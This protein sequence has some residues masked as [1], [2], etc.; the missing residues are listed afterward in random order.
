TRQRAER[1]MGR[2]DRRTRVTRAEESRGVT[3]GNRFGG[4]FDRGT[5]LA[6][7][8]SS[9]RFFHSDNV[10]C[11]QQFQAR[12]V[13]IGMALDLR[14]ERCQAAD[15]YDAEVEV[16][17]RS[18]RPVNEVGGAGVAA[19]R[20]NGDPDHRSKVRTKCLLFIDWTRL[21]AAI[22][23]AIRAHTMRR[24]GLGAM[25]AFAQGDGFECVVRPALRRPR[26][27]MSSFGIWHMYITSVPSNFRR[28]RNVQEFFFNAF[29][30]ASRGSSHAGWH[31]HVPRFRFIPHTE[32][33]PRQ[34]SWH[35][36][37]IGSTRENWSRIT[38]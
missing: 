20:I 27:G 12:W 4:H 28:A 14:L 2:Y 6:P 34:S 26:L 3:S 32:Q 35:N 10:L 18:Q 30:T 29:S 13:D 33:S 9:R 8:G 15:E 25:R 22:V 11:I 16:T 5:R 21:P 38:L 23:P 31:V 24:F 7:Q 1:G 37:F 19:H 36:G 17:N